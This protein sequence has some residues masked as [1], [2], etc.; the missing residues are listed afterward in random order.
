MAGNSSQSPTPN[1]SWST[2]RSETVDPRKYRWQGVGRSTR[3]ARVRPPR[4]RKLRFGVGLLCVLG[5]TSALVY[6]LLFTP[7]KTPLLVIAPTEYTAAVPPQDWTQEDVDGLKQLDGKTFHVVDTS[8]AWS[9][10]KSGLAELERGLKGAAGR[11]GNDGAVVVYVALHGLV[12]ETGRPCLLLPESSPLDSDEWLPVEELFDLASTNLPSGVQLV[13]LLDACRLASDWNLAIVRNTFVERVEQLVAKRQ[14][15]N[16]HVITSA[17]PGEASWAS[18]DVRGSVF[19]RAVRR[20]LSGEADRGSIDG[21]KIGN[22]NGRVSLNELHRYVA[23]ECQAWARANRGAEQSPRLFTHTTSGATDFRLAWSLGRGEVSALRTAE[24]A[25]TRAPDAV[26]VE[27]IVGQ[28]RK[29]DALRVARP[30][31][32]HPLL[33]RELENRLRRLERLSAAGEAY[34]TDA[35]RLHG[36]LKT[37]LDEAAVRA[38][39]LTADGSLAARCAILEPETFAA[40]ASWRLHS[41][42]WARTCGVLDAATVATLRQQGA[43]DA[44]GGTLLSSRIADER[45]PSIR[46]STESTLARLLARYRV[47]ERWKNGDPAREAFELQLRTDDLAVGGEPRAERWMRPALANVD[48][49]RREGLDRLF[50]GPTPAGNDVWLATRSALDRLGSGERSLRNELETALAVHDRGWAEAAHWAVWLRRESTRSLVREADVVERRLRPLLEELRR[51]SEEID[52]APPTKDEPPAFLARAAALNGELAAL[53]KLYDDAITKLLNVAEADGETVR[54]LLAALETPFPTAER[55]LAMLQKAAA[56]ATQLNGP[57]A[58]TTDAAPEAAAT[59]TAATE[60]TTADA[61]PPNGSTPPQ[62]APSATATKTDAA[63]VADAKPSTAPLPTTTVAPAPL[64]HPHPLELLLQLPTSD[65]PGAADEDDALHDVEQL[66]AAVRTK[67][68][69]MRNWPAEVKTPADGS[70]RD[71]FATAARQLRAFAPPAVATPRVNPVAQLRKF[72]LQQT[73]LWDVRRTLDD[74]WGTTTGDD[75]STADAAPF[76]DVAAS[77]HLAIAASLL[78]L[79]GPERSE[80]ESLEKLLNRRRAAARRGATV[81]V[82]TGVP[83]EKP[84]AL[85]ASVRIASGLGTETADGAAT[86]SKTTAE[87]WLP[88]GLGTVLARNGDAVLPLAPQS[89]TTPLAAA[90]AKVE[91]A[92]VVPQSFGSSFEAVAMLRGNEFRAPFA[93][94]GLGG[95]VI[96]FQPSRP[97]TAQ[98]TLFGDRPQ[99]ASVMFIL[100]SSASMGSEMPV[101]LVDAQTLPRLEIAKSALNALLEQLAIRADTRVGVRVFGHRAGWAKGETGKLMI[102]T[103]YAGPIPDDISPSGDVEL[104]LPLGRFDTVEAGLVSSRLKTTKPWGQSPLYL[105]LLDSLRDFDSDRDH[106]DK[107]I[108]VITDGANYQFTPSGDQGTANQQTLGDVL[109][110]WQGKKVPIYILGFGMGS[111]QDAAA[112]REFTALAEQTGGKYFVV[113]NGRDVLRTLRERLGFGS[114]QVEA[115]TLGGADGGSLRLN[116]PRTISGLHGPRT[117]YTVRFQGA[118]A[119]VEVEGG[120]GLELFAGRDGRIAARPYEVD[121]PTS[122]VMLLDGDPRRLTVRAHRPRAGGDVV[123]FPV[124]FQDA[125]ADFTPRPVETW[126]EIYP[127]SAGNVDLTP[128]YVF[129]DRKFENGTPVPVVLCPATAWPVKARQGRLRVW[130]KYGRTEPFQTIPLAEVQARRADYLSGLD[131]K[132]LE[133]IRLRVQLPERIEGNEPVEIK[134]IEEHD[135]RS[136]GLN[137]MKITLE[138]DAGLLPE[139]VVRR[140]DAARRTAIHSFHYSADAARRLLDSAAGR[141]TLVSRNAALDGAFQVEGSRALTVD[142]VGT[143]DLLPLDAATGVR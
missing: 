128:R 39:K 81:A 92:G 30:Y 67:L 99:E 59:G 88:P 29:L 7:V 143:G 43:L 42:A 76:F 17:G 108:V 63:R 95:V 45:M 14:Q 117:P 37:R 102:Q 84:D 62:P 56:F 40:A 107:S 96:D 104:V 127:V 123:R 74:F 22:R 34:R 25:A 106:T 116:A 51:L 35:T 41:T 6:A 118:S 55:R 112:Q 44:A 38:E 113:E 23:V 70:P 24:A 28:W 129:Y 50:L 73:L 111:N 9:Q 120:E 68:V 8:P 31:Q 61:A 122:D 3:R 94:P 109:A 101:E 90:G 13:V 54:E 21:E 110:A 4:R 132:A 71:V 58:E 64:T 134:V 121:L 130:C 49:A 93:R 137:R 114:Y 69:A 125:E 115:A 142:I 78:P 86:E 16:L 19:G 12:D 1:P 32:T 27:D 20:A 33:W 10:K 60:A 15:A 48:A 82:E 98:V 133:G 2:G 79:G 36:E 77:D 97:D 103:G 126:I 5:A 141:V 52:A 87:S 136:S 65:T 89:W 135:D 105:A 80:F 85:A 83:D 72:D 75:R 124:S 46:T 18:A 53:R 139:R 91:L 100:D 119:R 66:Q 47:V 26:A 57:P 11:R 138:N 140:Y 131:V